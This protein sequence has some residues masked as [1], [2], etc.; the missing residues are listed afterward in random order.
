MFPS[1][2][3]LVSTI[4]SQNPTAPT[5]GAPFHLARS[6]I[7][8][9]ATGEC[10]GDGLFAGQD[11]SAGEQITSIERPL[12]GSIDT[13]RLK[14]TCANCYVWTE[15]SSLGSRLYVKD[16]TKVQ[17]CAGCKRFRYCSKPCQKEAWNRGHKHECKALKPISDKEIPKAVLAAMELLIRRKHGLIADSDW[18]LLCRLDTHIDDFKRNGKYGGIELMA[19]GTSQFSWTQDTF[20]KDFVAGM[21][22]RILTN[23]L[24]IVT[25]TFDPLG[26]MVDPVLSHLNHSCDPNAFIVMDGSEAVIR[27][28][29]PI[30]KDEEILISYIDTTNPYARRQSELQAR[31]FFTCR[32]KKCQKGATCS[33]DKW[34]ISPQNL[35]SEW[36]A[37]ADDLIKSEAETQS[38]AN[39]VGD[40]RDEKRVAALQAK[41]FVL[42]EEQQTAN[43]LEAIEKIRVGMRLCHQSG[44]WPPHRQPYAALREDLILN[45]LSVGKYRDAW[46]HSAKRYWNILPALYQ[47]KVHPLRVVHM[48]QTAMLALYLANESEPVAPGVELGLIAYALISEVKDISQLSHGENSA[49]AR[50]VQRKYGEIA[51]EMQ[52]ELGANA[53]DIMS[54]A[55]KQQI[56]LFREMSD[57]VEY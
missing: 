3:I 46:T 47:E 48:W 33:E 18:V 29:K 44:L 42:Y 12:I 34:A 50:S 4:T 14:D 51:T 45:L 11:Y 24:T 22:A 57:R 26:I 23:S 27:T 55:I 43:P 54:S 35:A 17:T 40:S 7:C 41:A 9:T 20:S 32:C 31:W 8:V 52:S 2:D 39:H 25:P 37:I 16:G 5:I 21:Y 53:G 13:Q 28:L 1:E 15:G 19:M 30:E 56:A 49:F 38:P 6:P 36:K 10:I